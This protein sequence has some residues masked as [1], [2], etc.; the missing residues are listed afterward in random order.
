MYFRESYSERNSSTLIPVCCKN[1]R[2]R[3][4]GQIS[5]MIWNG[6][7]V[8]GIGIPPNL[9]ASACLA[10]EYKSQPP[11]FTSYLPIG[12]TCQLSHQAPHG[13][14]QFRSRLIQ[15]TQTL[16]QRVTVFAIRFDEL[17][18][19]VLGNLNC[20]SHCSA[21]RHQA[22]QIIGSRKILTRFQLSD[23]KT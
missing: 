14:R 19:H 23:L 20:L 1:R 3:T 16:G 10:V 12:E 4:F 15:G 11:Q 22:G 5:L 6:C 17:P 2:K 18:C 7:S 9:V 13:D 8:P 21:L